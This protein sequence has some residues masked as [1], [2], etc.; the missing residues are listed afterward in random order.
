[1]DRERAPS[2]WRTRRTPTWLPPARSGR[3][4]SGVLG[5]PEPTVRIPVDGAPTEYAEGVRILGTRVH[6]LSPLT[7]SP[8]WTPCFKIS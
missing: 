4:R 7:T 5:F 6:S 2:P 1:M 3:S 8:T